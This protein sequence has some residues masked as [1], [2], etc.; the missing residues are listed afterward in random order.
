MN[1][2]N[3]NQLDSFFNLSFDSK[4]TQCILT[5]AKW[6]RIGAI[7][8]FVGYGIALIVAVFGKNSSIDADSVGVAATKAG[9]IAGAFLSG[10]IG[11]IINYFLYRFSTAARQGVEGM[12][13]LRLNQGLG[14]LRTYFKI[15]GI[16]I[17][18]FLIIACLAIL[19]GILSVAFMKH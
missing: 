3:Q 19:I 7:C 12:D 5:I 17:L 1:T 6:A 4:A 9:N 14:D 11:T 8:S 10:I 15:L 18:I 16:I 13:Q 2:E